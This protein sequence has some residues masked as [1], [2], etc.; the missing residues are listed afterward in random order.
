VK[1]FARMLEGE[2]DHIPEQFFFLQGTLDDVI[3]DYEA[4]R[5]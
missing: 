5:K 2:V 4:S 3:H 1:S